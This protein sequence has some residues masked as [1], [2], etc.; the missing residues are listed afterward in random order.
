MTDIEQLAALAARGQV[1][2]PATA[3][4]LADCTDLDGLMQAAA[5]LRDQGFGNGVTYSRKIFIPLTELCRDVC[6]Y[7]TFAKAPRKVGAAYMSLDAVVEL[8]R[9]ARRSGARRF[10]HLGERPELRYRAAREALDALGYAST[11]DYLRAAAAAVFDA[12]GL[13]PHMN[14]GT[15]SAAECAM[16][17]EVAPSMGIMLESAS[18]RLCAKGM[19]HHGSPDKHPAA[20]LA[21]LQ[22]AGEARIP[23]T[24][25]ILIGIGET[26]RERIEALLAIRELHQRYGHIQEI[27]VQN[28]RAKPGT[29]MA[30]APEPDLADMQW[31]LAVT[32]L[33]FGP[34]M[35]LQ[36]PPNL[37][38]GRLGALIDAGIND[39]G[40]VSPLTPD[41]VN[42][43][44]P[45]PHL[46]QLARDTAAA[47]KHLHERMTIYPAYVRAPSAWVD[48]RFVT[49]LLRNSDADGY[50]RTDDWSPGEECAPPAAVVTAVTTPPARISRDVARILAQVDDGMLLA[51]DAIERLFRARGDDFAAVCQAADRLRREVNGEVV[52]YV[53]NR[54]I[55]YTNVCYFKCQFCAFSKGKLSENLRGSPYDLDF[56]EIQRRVREAWARGATEVCMQGGIHPQYTGQTYLDILARSRRRSP[57]CTFMPSPRSKSG[58]VR[59]RPGS[60]CA[61]FSNG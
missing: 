38:P 44:A 42:P 40:G 28:F 51:D 49:P 52:S 1:P 11:L 13:L 37:S 3:L 22:A 39:W 4:A 35:S 17:R 57:K 16:L 46:E 5:A 12:T 60:I 47:G 61:R 34:D 54:I 43:E 21:T 25:G 30:D 55:N 8:A 10:V 53:V 7:C 58:R 14:P 19:P 23:F 33:L 29:R 56:D 59:R 45:W 24:T 15:L 20:R 6:H 18:E 27:I 9:P 48:A 32:R 26:R 36:A 2:T 31:T 41:H 50:P